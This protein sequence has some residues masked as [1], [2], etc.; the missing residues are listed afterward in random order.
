MAFY[1]IFPVIYYGNYKKAFPK[2]FATPMYLFNCLGLDIQF[3][4]KI[5][6]KG[7]LKP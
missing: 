7:E 1:Q 5:K 6:L 4:H 3:D 2:V